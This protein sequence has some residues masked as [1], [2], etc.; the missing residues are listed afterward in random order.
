M[1]HVQTVK[2]ELTLVIIGIEMLL[3][4]AI[5]SRKIRTMKWIKVKAR[6]YKIN[7]RKWKITTKQILITVRLKDL[8][9]TT[10]Y[11]NRLF[12]FQ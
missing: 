4:G 6:H 11:H 12:F 5:P 9:K 2:T 1:D 3:K 7:G 10:V 8:G